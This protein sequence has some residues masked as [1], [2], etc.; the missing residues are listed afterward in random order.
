MLRGVEEETN[1][2]LASTTQNQ[3][4]TQHQPNQ[5]HPNI[6][7][8]NTQTRD[9]FEWREAYTERFGMIYIDL[10]DNLRR[11]PKAS[12]LWFAKNFWGVSGRFGPEYYHGLFRMRPADAAAAARAL[13][14][15]LL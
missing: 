7:T 3:S 5:H 14:N 4:T 6:T 1:P 15:R 10:A 8:A 12:A 2:S 9:N 13:V 11:I